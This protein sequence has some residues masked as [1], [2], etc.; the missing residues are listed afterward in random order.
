MADRPF[1]EREGL[2]KQTPLIYD[3]APDLPLA[4][5]CPGLVFAVLLNR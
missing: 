2:R 1:S 5:L 3:D 4:K